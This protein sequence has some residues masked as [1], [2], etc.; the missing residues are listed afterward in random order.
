MYGVFIDCETSGGNS[1]D[2][3]G[4]HGALD[5]VTQQTVGREVTIAN[6]IMNLAYHI[7]QLILFTVDGLNPASSHTISVHKLPDARF[8]DTIQ[9]TFNILNVTVFKLDNKGASLVLKS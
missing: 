5:D 8:N 2:V 6:F 1:F 9:L 4:A 3:V 7:S